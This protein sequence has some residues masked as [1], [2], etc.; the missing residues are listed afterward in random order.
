[1]VTFI[2]V[3]LGRMEIRIAMINVNWTPPTLGYAMESEIGMSNTPVPYYFHGG[4]FY[5][6]YMHLTE[7]LLG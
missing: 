1:M 4:Q 3:P 6:P 5:R 7:A 2:V